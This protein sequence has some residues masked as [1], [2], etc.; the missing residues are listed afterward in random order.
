MKKKFLSIVSMLLVV[1]SLFSTLTGC[2]QHEFKRTPK[3]ELKV[4]DAT[5]EH[6]TIYKMSCECGEVSE[7]TFQSGATLKYE[8]GSKAD[9]LDGK[10]ILFVGNSFTY[11][12]NVVLRTEREY[13]KLD[14]NRLNDKGYFYEFCKQSGADV[15]VTDWCYGGHG[16][17]DSLGD[18]CKADRG[19]DGFNHYAE[20]TDKTYDYVILQDTQWNGGWEL[21]PD[22][23]NW[24]E[25]VKSVAQIF[26]DANPNVKVLFFFQPAIIFQADSYHYKNLV[27]E[28]EDTSDITVV[29]WGSLVYDVWTGAVKVPNS[30]YTYNKESFIVSQSKADGYH[31]NMLSGYITTLMLYCTITGETAVGQPFEFAS[32]Y[33]VHSMFNAVA[34]KYTYYTHIKD[35]NFDLILKDAEEMRNIQILVDQYVRTQQYT[36]YFN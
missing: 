3:D 30:K 14:E 18:G 23:N 1:C 4:A 34:F 9:M 8:V 19:C 21:D 22:Y 15:S 36:K 25:Y 11:F 24:V 20:L 28:L 17:K 29:D 10:K 32:D 26:K 16:L 5:Y 2:H 33:N 31:Q 35:T 27:K 7:Q 6:A 13:Q 12:G